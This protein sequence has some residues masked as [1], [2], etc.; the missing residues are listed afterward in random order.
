MKSTPIASS[1]MAGVDRHLGA[2]PG[3]ASPEPA[4][5]TSGIGRGY[6]CKPCLRE[7]MTRSMGRERRSTMQVSP[8]ESATEDAGGKARA[9]LW[10]MAAGLFV[11]LMVAYQV[12]RGL[13]QGNDAKPNVY[14]AAQIVERG[15]LAF[16][17]EEFPFVFVWGLW[18]KQWLIPDIRFTSW[19]KNTADRRDNNATVV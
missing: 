6:S 3:I 8:A 17:P 19:E 1:R 10:R 16:T 4:S 14:L 9:A 11:G 15:K 5:R 18:T 12:N 13:L 2:G 7:R